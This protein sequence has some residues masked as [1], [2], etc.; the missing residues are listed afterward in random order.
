MSKKDGSSTCIQVDTKIRDFIR[1]LQLL[2]SSS[3]GEKRMMNDIVKQAME[4]TFPEELKAY[5]KFLKESRNAS[6]KSKK[7]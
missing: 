7:D 1:Y 3:S 2:S 5:K 4:T 6:R